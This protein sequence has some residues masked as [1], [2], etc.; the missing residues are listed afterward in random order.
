MIGVSVRVWGVLDQDAASRRRSAGGQPW[1]APNAWLLGYSLVRRSASRYALAAA[2]A[3]SGGGLPAAIR[4][5]GATRRR[6]VGRGP[7]RVLRGGV[8]TDFPPPGVSNS[9]VTQMLV[10]TVFP[11]AAA[12]L[13]LAVSART[14][15]WRGPGG[16]CDRRRSSRSGTVSYGIYLWHLTVNAWTPDWI[17]PR[18]LSS[19][20]GAFRRCWSVSI[21]G[22]DRDAQLPGGRATVDAVVGAVEPAGEPAAGPCPVSHGLVIVGAEKPRRRDRSRPWCSARRRSGPGRRPANPGLVVAVAGTG[23]R[24]CSARSRGGTAPRAA[25]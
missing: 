14:H 15:R 24:R 3:A 2:W 5:C 25:K 9:A 10:T 7:R 12:L 21:T 4:W 1:R 23:T 19:E 8:G 17:I 16:C 11:M 13:V 6:G 20:H 22:V 18:S